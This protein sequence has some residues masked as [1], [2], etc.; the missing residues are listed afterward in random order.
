MDLLLDTN[1]YIWFIE[2]DPRLPE[3]IRLQ[4]DA[5]NVSVWVSTATIWEMAIK[6]NTIR[7]GKRALDLS[8]PVEVLVR[9]AYVQSNIKVLPIRLRHVIESGKLAKNHLDPFDRVIIAQ[10]MIDDFVIISSDSA[11]DAYPVTRLW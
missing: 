2:D 1:A 4:I 7:K 3:H 8:K 10:A 11:F 6:Y 5:P 9:E